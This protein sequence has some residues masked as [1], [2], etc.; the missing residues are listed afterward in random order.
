MARIEVPAGPGLEHQRIWQL[1]PYLGAALSTMTTAVYEQSSLPVRE[2]EVARMRIAQLNECN[3]C[4]NT[5]AAGAMRQGLSDEL[6]RSVDCY[7]DLDE[8]TPREK[9]AAELAEQFAIDHT[10]I[11]DELW[12][13]LHDAFSDVEL[14]ELVV[15]IGFCVGLGRAFNVLDIARDFDVNWSKEPPA[16]SPAGS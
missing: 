14:L 1:A 2:R 8:L 10:R 3:V 5:R 7:R 6:Y 12:A 4:L 11:G 13:R 16:P 9:L 15:T